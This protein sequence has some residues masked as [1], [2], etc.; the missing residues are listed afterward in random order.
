DCGAAG[1]YRAR[2]AIVDRDLRRSHS[3]SASAPVFRRSDASRDCG[4][5]GLYRAR[6]AIVD[7][8][9]RRSRSPCASAA[10]FVGATQVAI[11]AACLSPG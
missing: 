11:T 9:W 8:D 7:R 10:I 2:F 5:A 6:F 1:L 4:A 3:A